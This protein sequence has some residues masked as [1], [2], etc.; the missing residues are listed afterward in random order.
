MSNR[1]ILI[2]FF[3]AFL[4][5]FIKSPRIVLSDAT[6]PLKEVHFTVVDS[7]GEV[8]ADQS[9]SI[10]VTDTADQVA[11]YTN[12][13]DLSH[14]ITYTEV[15]G[16]FGF[17]RVIVSNFKQS[18]RIGDIIDVFVTIGHESQNIQVVLTSETDQ[19]P[20]NDSSLK[21]ILVETTL[22]N[23]NSAILDVDRNGTVNATDG[24]LILRRLNGA[25]TID[26]GLVLPNGIT[27]SDLVSVI[28]QARTNL[29]FDVDSNGTVNATDGVLILR[30]LNGAS[31]IDTGLVLPSGTTNSDV[32]SVIDNLKVS[33]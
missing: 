7:R 13:S 14:I 23:N 3:C 22:S 21:L 32:V 10:T 31:T 18:W 17:I 20:D 6:T 28:D 25:S 26:T 24:V 5:S 11:T 27:N 9:I 2:V 12:T 8:P 4:F 1:K 15:I 33:Q 16:Y 30:R 19:K 29:A